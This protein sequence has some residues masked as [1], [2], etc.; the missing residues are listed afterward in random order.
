[1]TCIHFL[2][3]CLQRESSK[4]NQSPKGFRMYISKRERDRDHHPLH[5]T[6]YSAMKPDIRTDRILV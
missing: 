4:R 5:R 2:S 6:I 1:M 3:K